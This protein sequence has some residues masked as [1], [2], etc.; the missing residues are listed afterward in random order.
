MALTMEEA[1]QRDY[2][3]HRAMRDLVNTIEAFLAEQPTRCHTNTGI[4]LRA[5]ARDLEGDMAHIVAVWD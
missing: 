4:T 1:H 2:Q 3:D 5:A